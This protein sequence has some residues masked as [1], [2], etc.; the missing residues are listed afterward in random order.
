MAVRCSADRDP[1]ARVVEAA[2]RWIGTPYRHQASCRGVGTDCLGLVRGLWRE[3]LGTEPEHP[4]AYSADWAEASGEERLLQAAQR[5]LIGVPIHAAMA[6]DVLLFRMLAQG[7]AKHVA[8]LSSDALVDG[9]I[10]HAY[11]GHEVCETHLSQAWT[12]RLTAVFRFPL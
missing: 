3:M 8:V 1:E 2:R 11:S 6:G 10:I 4:G 5:N 7:P 9:R 12:K